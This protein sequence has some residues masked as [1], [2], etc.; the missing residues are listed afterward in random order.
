MVFLPNDA[1]VLVKL[2]A[3]RIRLLQL[4]V[5]MDT[6]MHSIMTAKFPLPLKGRVVRAV[7]KTMIMVRAP[8]EDGSAPISLALHYLK[9][10]LPNVVVKGK[11]TFIR[12]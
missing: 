3:K 6:I 12:F 11:Q 1:F 8:D 4:E 5:T 2:S 9:Y 7:G 10:F